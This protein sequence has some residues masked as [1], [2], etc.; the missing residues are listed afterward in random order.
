MAVNLEETLRRLV[1]D[2]GVAG[3]AAG[4]IDRR[5]VEHVAATGTRGP[6]RGSVDEHTVFAAASLTKPVFATACADLARTG[7]LDLDRPLQEYL[8]APYCNDARTAS[9]TA[10][11]VLNHTTGFPNWRHDEPLSLRWSPGSRWGYSGEGFCYLQR[12]VEH[13]TG[14]PLHRYIADAVLR[15]LG[16]DHSTLSWEDVDQGR[17]AVGHGPNGK[18][19]PRFRPP[20]KKAAAGGL[21]TTV[22]DY[23]RFLVDSLSHTPDAPEPQVWIDDGLGWRLGWGVED[24]PRGRALWQWG[25]DPGYKNFV[26]G[27][28]A[29]GEGV[30]VFT[31]DDRG[32]SVYSD[33]VRA[34]LPGTHPSLESGHR[35]RWMLA[36]APRLVDLE[37]RLDE[38]GV[39]RL[40]GVV[41]TC[42]DTE[43][44]D[45][46]VRQV[47]SGRASLLG[48]AVQESWEAVDLP[49]GTPVACIGLSQA[50]GGEATISAL[51]VL[52]GWRRQGLATSVIFGAA[53][54]LDLRTL[55]V[56]DG[57]ALE[58]FRAAGFSIT[59]T[60][61]DA[62]S[63][64]HVRCRLELPRPLAS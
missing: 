7:V 62:A 46:L 54:Q 57:Q 9:I 28:P 35:P 12:V 6:G 63:P 38:P 5:G 58:F 20:H 15:P 16:M 50:R 23:L 61:G 64:E 36:M 60:G 59:G 26:I 22:G 40:L 47:R 1:D 8:D 29:D 25:N 19:R 42:G 14:A 33:V 49:V 48:I 30:V 2:H 52:P 39:Q 31:N 24:T 32:V 53:E 41:A 51:A 43:R 37:R 56:E 18:T 10:G 44:V 55:D 4:T 27:R 34:L 13:L 11:M 3:A 45:H 21:F 17:L